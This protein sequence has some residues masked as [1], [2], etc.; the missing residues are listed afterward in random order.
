[1]GFIGKCG[2]FAERKGLKVLQREKPVEAL[3]HNANKNLLSWR[4]KRE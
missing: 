4:A 1:M 3:A 2:T